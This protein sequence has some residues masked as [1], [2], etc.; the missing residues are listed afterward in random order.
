MTRYIDTTGF[1]PNN[2]AVKLLSKVLTFSDGSTVEI[3]AQMQR[4]HPHL[5]AVA[6]RRA[7]SIRQVDEKKPLDG[8][9]GGLSSAESWPLFSL[10]TVHKV[11]PRKTPRSSYSICS[12]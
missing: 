2:D 5:F 12:G 7:K 11:F 6:C 1:I 10:L 3:D 8:K 9:M 4:D